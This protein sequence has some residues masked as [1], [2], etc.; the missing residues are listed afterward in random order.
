MLHN[1]EQ[2]Q[3]SPQFWLG[4]NLIPAVIQDHETL[5]VLMV[6]YM[7]QATW[8]LTLTGKKVC[9]FSRKKNR[10][11]LKGEKSGH[12][13][14]VKQVSLNCDNTC[15]LVRVHQIGGCCDLG[16]K[17]C[18]D[19]VLE[20]DVFV[21]AGDKVFDPGEAYREEYT[22][23]IVL[24]IPTGSLRDMTIKLFELADLQ[25]ELQSE[26][27]NEHSVRNVSDIRIIMTAAQLLPVLVNR[28]LVDAAITG[29]DWVEESGASVKNVCDLGYNKLGLGPVGLALGIPH[30]SDISSLN[31]LNDRRVVSVYE[32]LV[33]TFFGSRGIRV[34]V[35]PPSSVQSKEL[36]SQTDA[37]V[38]LI[39]TGATFH[40]KQLTPVLKLFDTSTHLI[41]NTESWGYTWKRRRIEQIASKLKVAATKLPLNRK[42]NVLLRSVSALDVKFENQETADKYGP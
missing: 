21:S 23:G 41:A 1:I 32:N 6:G 10:V 42:T 29:R 7:N 27:A 19:K 11:W 26:Y 16:L 18:F 3:A 28:G 33:Q 22:K 17:S 5:E 39:E 15:L 38:D 8:E 30:S 31:D 37:V 35:S 12:Y 2:R 13:Q 25:L 4:D 24:G 34:L 9:Y 36:P 14:L 20:G 40:S